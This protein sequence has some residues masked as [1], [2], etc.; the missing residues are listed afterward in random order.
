MTRKEIKNLQDLVDRYRYGCG[1]SIEVLAKEGGVSVAT[2]KRTFGELGCLDLSG[3]V[4]RPK[5]RKTRRASPVPESSAQKN[6][7]ARPRKEIPGLQDLGQ[8]FKKGEKLTALSKEA[9][10]S[11]PTLRD[12]LVEEG[13]IDPGK[14]LY[15]QRMENEFERV[16]VNRILELASKGPVTVSALLETLH[17]EGFGH[18]KAYHVTYTLKR[19]GI[20]PARRG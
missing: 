18:L 8:R 16:P 10:V 7:P 14:S 5:P 2:L 9:G 15:R 11:F 17:A 6:S 13:F 12:R 4:I 3:R 1:E 19:E 20:Y